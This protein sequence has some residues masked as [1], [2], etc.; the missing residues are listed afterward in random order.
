MNRKH[1]AIPPHPD[2]RFSEAKGFSLYR[3]QSEHTTRRETCTRAQHKRRK[4]R[5]KGRYLHTN[6]YG[7]G[8]RGCGLLGDACFR[9]GLTGHK[10]CVFIKRVPWVFKDSVEGQKPPKRIDPRTNRKR[11]ISRVE[12]FKVSKSRAGYPLLGYPFSLR[13]VRGAKPA[14]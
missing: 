10:G 13:F 3:T 1:P 6:G 5:G 9:T 7:F 14:H 2:L 8:L 11:S 4:N 12:S